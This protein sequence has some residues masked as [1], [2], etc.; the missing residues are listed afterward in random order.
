MKKAGM[1]KA[2]VK[3]A[4]VKKAGIIIVIALLALVSYRVLTMGDTNARV[5]EDIRLNPNGERAQRTMIVTLADGRQYPVT[6][7]NSGPRT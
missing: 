4:G 7:S 5:S 1:K 6:N 2:G 3:K